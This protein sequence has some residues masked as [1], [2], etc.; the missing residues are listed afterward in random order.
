MSKTRSMKEAETKCE[1]PNPVNALLVLKKL[2]DR[3]IKI[4]EVMVPI[5]QDLADEESETI[6]EIKFCCKAEDTVEWLQ[7][8]TLE[9]VSEAQSANSE[10]DQFIKVYTSGID[11]VEK[12]A[13]EF[14]F[15]ASVWFGD[16]YD[17]K[18]EI[19]AIA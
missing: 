12:H 6:K 16:V 17:G 8:Q 5:M 3:A 9:A 19:E 1:E 11:N 7:E 2:K 13:K 10:I 18:E 14:P 4:L 15:L